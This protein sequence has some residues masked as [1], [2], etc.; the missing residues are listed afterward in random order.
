MPQIGKLI[1]SESRLVVA[2][3]CGKGQWQVIANGYRVSF[4]GD[5]SILKLIVVMVM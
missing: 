3:G 1:K 5:G 4:G 2:R